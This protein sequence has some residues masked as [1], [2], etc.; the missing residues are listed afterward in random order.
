M[1]DALPSEFIAA[2]RCHSS[3]TSSP[4]TATTSPRRTTRTGSSSRWTRSRRSCSKAQIA[5]EDNRFYEHGGVDLQGIPA[6]LDLQ[7]CGGGNSLRV[8]PTL[9]QQYVKIPC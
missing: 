5:I 3:R 2:R 7:P 8:G 9:T 6:R 4:P 1:F